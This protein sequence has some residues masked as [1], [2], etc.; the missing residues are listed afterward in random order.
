MP[1]PEREPFFTLRNNKQNAVVGIRFNKPDGFTKSFW[2]ELLQKQTECD[3]KRILALI[4]ASQN[5][6]SNVRTINLREEMQ[7]LSQEKRN[8]FLSDLAEQ[9]AQSM[10]VLLIETGEE[11]FIPIDNQLPALNPEK[12]LLEIGKDSISEAFMTQQLSEEELEGLLKK[13]D[14]DRGPKTIT[15]QNGWNSIS[16]FRIDPTADEELIETARRSDWII[17]DHDIFSRREYLNDL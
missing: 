17:I 4:S 16:V 1:A 12:Y 2:L 9:I 10:K 11:K 13:L 14:K 6:K 3:G 8:D 7:G 15:V 5:K